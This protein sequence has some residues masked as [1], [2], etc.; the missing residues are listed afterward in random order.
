M[1]KQHCDAFHPDLQGCIDP[2]AEEYDALDLNYMIQE[3]DLINSKV[4]S[5]TSTISK[6]GEM[7]S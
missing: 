4:R 7:K 2:K 5:I 3:V 1:D 6:I